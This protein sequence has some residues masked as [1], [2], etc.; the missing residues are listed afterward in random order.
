V[1]ISYVQAASALVVGLGPTSL[2]ANLSGH[3]TV[4]NAIIVTVG[5]TSSPSFSVSDNLGN[6]YTQLATRS[7]TTL[8]TQVY[9]AQVTTGGSCA[10]TATT[11]GASSAVM[12]VAEYSP[13]SGMIISDAVLYSPGLNNSASISGITL[14]NPPEL[15]YASVVTSVA[16]ITG[17]GSPWTERINAGSGPAIEQEDQVSASSGNPT[18]GFST[19]TTYVAWCLSF[20]TTAASI[21]QLTSQPSQRYDPLPDFN[22]SFWEQR[23]LWPVP[24]QYI[25]TPPPT[26][27]LSQRFD[28]LFDYNEQWWEQF[29]FQPSPI[30][31]L[32]IGINPNPSQRQD[33]LPDFNSL[34]WQQL[35]LHPLPSGIVTSQIGT[36]GIYNAIINASQVGISRIQNAIEGYNVWVGVGSLPDLA[37]APYAFSAELPITVA[38]TPPVS[39]TQTYYVLVTRQDTYGLNSVNQFYTTITLDSN[40]NLIVPAPPTPQ[41]I[42]LYQ[43]PGGS[44]RV[45]ASYPTFSTD[46]YPATAWYIW[47]GTTLPNPATT[48]TMVVPASTNLGTYTPVQSPGTYYVMVAL[49]QGANATLSGTI[50]TT[51]TVNADPGEVIAVPSGWNM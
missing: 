24:V 9:I 36:S 35:R 45:L 33:Q 48:P 23:K 34:W 28:P 6:T 20:Y 39:G 15:I 8:E 47:I 21:T 30:T 11:S 22:Y 51:V 46:Q 2:T 3:V 41:N 29:R 25:P 12:S 18:W 32:P 13:S 50:Y 1:T 37:A 5:G 4:G 43:Q 26:K 17:T 14:T 7:E 31:F 49:Y 16:S 40:G 10:V 27:Q 44:I 19:T 38:L 42:V